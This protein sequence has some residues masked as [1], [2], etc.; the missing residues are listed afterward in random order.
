ML[1][2]N[3]SLCVNITPAYDRISKIRARSSTRHEL[4][5]HICEAQHVRRRCVSCSWFRVK[6][7]E[8]NGS[9]KYKRLIR[10]SPNDAD[11]HF[12]C[13]QV[14][15]SRYVQLDSSTPAHGRPTVV[16]PTGRQVPSGRSPAVG[17]YEGW[18]TSYMVSVDIS[19]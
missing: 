2:K 18:V 11:E 9:T 8:T 19:A 6:P 4:K 7:V 14:V 5:F 13:E 1:H 16:G 15:H 17:T 12:W 3:Y 10:G